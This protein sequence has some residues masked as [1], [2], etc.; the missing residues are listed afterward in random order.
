VS[1]CGPR[2]RPGPT[3][4]EGGGVTLLAVACA[5]LL[6][7]VGSALGVVAAVVVAHR[8]AQSAADLAALAGASEV[9]VGGDGCA[10]AASLAAA[11]GASLTGCQVVGRDVTVQVVVPGPRWL[12]WSGDPA[13]RARAGP[14]GGT[15]PP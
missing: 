3:R 8:T 13:G 14:D 7:V 9:G 6:L 15:L 2:R 1:R 12:G 4:G 11:N 10:R 5:G